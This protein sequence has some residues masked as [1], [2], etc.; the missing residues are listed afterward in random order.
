MISVTETI[1]PKDGSRVYW[2]EFGLPSETFEGQAC[3]IVTEELFGRDQITIDVAAV[4]DLFGYR[5][6]GRGD[7]FGLGQVQYWARTA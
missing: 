4:L 1:N 5:C 7:Y 2:W 3:E 6:I